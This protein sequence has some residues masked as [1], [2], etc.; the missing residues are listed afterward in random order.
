MMRGL[1]KSIPLLDSSQAEQQRLHFERAGKFLG[2]DNSSPISLSYA[3]DVIA[4][5]LPLFIRNILRKI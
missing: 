4:F 3:Q 2:R 1:T 5:R